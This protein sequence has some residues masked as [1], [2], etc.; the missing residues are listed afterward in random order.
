MNRTIRTLLVLAIAVG[1]AAFASLSIYKV[2]Q[3]IPERQVE[4]A[5]VHAVVAAKSMP[6][7]TLLTADD[8]KLVGWPAKTPLS[9]GFSD[10]K[11]VMNRGLIAAVEQNEPITDSKLAPVGVGGGLPPSIPTGMR[12]ISVKVNEVIGVAGFVVPG[13]RVDVV[14]T[15]QRQTQQGAQDSMSRIVVTGVQ[16]LTAGTKIEQAKK[17][18]E[19][20]PSS[21]VTLLV[22][23]ED[24]EKI[25]LASNEGH[26]T[27]T[28]RN[29]VDT[30]PT[31]TQGVKMANLMGAPE[32]PAVV[33]LVKNQR[34]AVAPKPVVEEKPAPPP[35]Y[36]VETIRAAKRTEEVVK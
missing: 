4:V 19:P 1:V 9:G 5:T 25:A 13:T 6:M 14:V 12:A 17:D 18:S 16:V 34:V 15:V 3:R 26:I 28:L 10:E 8:V 33:K 27:L 29:P 31:E 35:Q 22:T 20:I 24:A 30:K 21:V 32:P 7:G 11:A 23:P 2:V 36:T